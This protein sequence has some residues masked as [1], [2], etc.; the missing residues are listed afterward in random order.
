[1]K[2]LGVARPNPVQNLAFVDVEL[3]ENDLTKLTLY[4]NTGFKIQTL[5]EG[6]A[7]KGMRT[8]GINA[9]DLSSCVYYLV[10]E[11]PTYSQTSKFEIV[12]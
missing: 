3:I 7:E 9:K 10:L 1:M 12:K 8:F 2:N 6:I 11:T 5:F 4:N